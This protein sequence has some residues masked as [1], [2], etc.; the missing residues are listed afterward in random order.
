MNANMRETIRHLTNA[1][2]L[3]LLLLSVAA[4]Y[5]Q[6]GDAAPLGGQQLVGGTMRPSRDSAPRRTEPLRGTIYDDKGNWI[7]KTVPDGKNEN[8]ICGYH[9]IY[10]QWVIDTGLAPLIGYYTY[11]HGMA[12]IEAQYNDQ[13]SGQAASNS[14]SDN[15]GN[16]VNKLLHKDQYGQDLYL[17]ID[18]AAQ[19]AAS[20]Y[21]DSSAEH[22][23]A[24]ATQANPAGSIIVEDPKSGAILAMV[25]KPDYDLNK[26]IAADSNDEVVNT[27]ANQYIAGLNKATVPVLINRAAQGL[28]APGSTFKT[29]TLSAALD[30]GY[31]LTDTSGDGKNSFTKDQALHFQVPSG[32]TIDWNDYSDFSA[33][34]NFPM[35]FQ[36][37]YALSDNVIYAR[38]GIELGFQTSAKYVGLYG[39][40][41][42]G[43]NWNTN[44]GFDAPYAQSIAYPAITTGGQAGLSNDALAESAF[45]QGKLLI[46]PLTMSVVTSAIANGGVLAKPH[47]G[48]ALAA[49]GSAEAQ[50]QQLRDPATDTAI[51]HPGTAQNLRQAM[52]AVASSGTG[53]YGNGVDPVFGTKLS[54]SSSRGR[55]DRYRAGQLRPARRVV[56]LARPRY[57]APG[58]PG[59]AQYVVIVNKQ[60]DPNGAGNNEG[61][62]QVYVAD[63]IYRTLLGIH[64]GCPP[65]GDDGTSCP[66]S[67]KARSKRVL[68]DDHRSSL[69]WK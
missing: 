14:A 23:G 51:L 53:S 46:S 11:T 2:I 61:A 39:I 28:Y 37:G 6:I 1:F 35:S 24:C 59:G 21:Y 54:N 38:L 69:V 44:V 42:P 45:G 55:Q 36:D 64:R 47:V 20:K 19:Q 33:V 17:T 4:A 29:V 49:Y 3:F 22:G 12:G 60:G 56:D 16:A 68:R 26:V 48:L 43:L 66:T 40:Q 41:T 27:P 25:S 58:A 67:R 30:Q 8:Y 50:G 34:A 31:P 57:Q 52:W 62:C 9:R 13:L 7:A 18:M 15:I 32:E 63:D 5:V 10:A 65:S